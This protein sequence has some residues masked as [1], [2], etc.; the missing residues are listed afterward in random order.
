[1]LFH[2]NLDIGCK[3]NNKNTGQPHL[4][5]RVGSISPGSAIDCLTLLVA[6]KSATDGNN[7]IF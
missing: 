1:L 2:K 6:R 4:H 5:F 7:H 3:E